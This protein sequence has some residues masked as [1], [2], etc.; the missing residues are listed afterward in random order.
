VQAL[1]FDDVDEIAGRFESLNP[2]AR[3]AVEGS[4]LKTE[5]INFADG[6]SRQLWCY[7][8]SSKRYAL[9][10]LDEHGDPHVA[11]NSKGE[12]H[13]SEHGL[14]HLLNPTN[15]DNDDREW[16]VQSWETIAREHLGLP[17]EKPAWLARAALT[18]LSI[19]TPYIR[20]PFEA[21]DDR[22]PYRER[23]KP[24]NFLL[25]AHIAP[26]GFPLGADKSRFLLVSGYRRDPRQWPKARWTDVH[27]KD[28]YRATTDR[29]R[30][31]YD[32]SLALIE[33]YEAAL[34]DFRLH[35]EAKSLCNGLPVDEDHRNSTGVLTRRAAFI[36]RGLIE[37]IGKESNELRQT[38][39]LVQDEDEVVQVYRD[40]SDVPLDR[41]RVLLRAIP[42][43]DTIAL[44]R[45]GERTIEMTRRGRSTPTRGNQERLLQ[46]I[47]TYFSD[48]PT[49]S[50][51]TIERLDPVS[52]ASEVRARASA[53]TGHLRLTDATLATARAEIARKYEDSMA[54]AIRP[55][56][57]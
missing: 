55:L 36:P 34:I 3:A 6:N 10:K 31:V 8:I 2:Y 27:S 54:A 19:S 15:I 48:H 30:R 13:C 28:V 21:D 40:R 37:N 49:P 51:E 43:R 53:A 44:T 50:F 1:T 14:G 39:G 12:A 47:T 4:I 38:P 18:Q 22:L 9:Y 46:A 33:T 23:I 42:K 29:Q 41:Y 35:P 24:F 5:G 25:A 17:T 16:I 45:L 20:R 57:L 32:P 7:A 56:S 11:R 52:I 26:G